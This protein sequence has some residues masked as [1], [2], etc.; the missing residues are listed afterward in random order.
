V[1]IND[2]RKNLRDLNE[3]MDLECRS[4]AARFAVSGS[5]CR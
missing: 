3:Y 4:A 5:F 2:L 1:S